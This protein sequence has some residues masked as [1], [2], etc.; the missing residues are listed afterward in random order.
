MA[1]RALR[2]ALLL[3]LLTPA[4][5]SA[6]SMDD[7]VALSRAGLADS[8]LVAVM[9]AD[10][11]IFNLT[12]QQILDLKDAGVSDAVV[13]RMVGTTPD[14]L[15]SSDEPGPGVVIIGEDPLPAETVYA[16]LAPYFFEPYVVG[17][18]Y[19]VFPFTAV[20]TLRYIDPGA[21]R[22]PTYRGGLGRS[23]NDGWVEGVGFGRFI[24]NGTI[25]RPPAVPGARPLSPV[26]RPMPP[27]ARPPGSYGR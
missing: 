1:G 21:I 18:P 4:T 10:G 11:S 8:I 27:A 2:V 5:G 15:F 22:L 17:L 12:A 26:V 13:A 24:N 6:V 14:L 7:I 25:R 16:D 9:D 19:N 20:P 23:I 3:V